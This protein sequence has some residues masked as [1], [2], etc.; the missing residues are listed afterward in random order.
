MTIVQLEKKLQELTIR[1]DSYCL[2]GGL[3]NEAYCISQLDNT[4]EVYYSERG[5]KTSKKV[6][7]D[8]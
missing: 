2:H 6:F 5:S 4:W 7:I 3:P 8:E 1:K